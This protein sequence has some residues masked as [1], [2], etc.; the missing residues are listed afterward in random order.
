MQTS[1]DAGQASQPDNQ[2]LA[3]PWSYYVIMHFLK[4]SVLKELNHLKEE[5]FNLTKK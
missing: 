5:H 3:K 4:K 1:V 2:L